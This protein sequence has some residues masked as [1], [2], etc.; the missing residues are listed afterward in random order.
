MN[1]KNKPIEKTNEE[2]INV[3]QTSVDVVLR[4]TTYKPVGHNNT[5]IEVD[6]KI[7]LPVF[8]IYS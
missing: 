4:N 1:N 8:T 6:T 7:V 5:I 2:Y 3:K